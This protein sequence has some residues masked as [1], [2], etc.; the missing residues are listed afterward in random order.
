MASWDW[1]LDQAMTWEKSV[2]FLKAKT[3]L[4]VWK[5]VYSLWS[6][7]SVEQS[8][9]L[10]FPLMSSADLSYFLCS[11]IRRN[12]GPILVTFTRFVCIYYAIINTQI[13]L[14]FLLPRFHWLQSLPAELW[15][16]LLNE[17]YEYLALF[18]LLVMIC[19]LQQCIGKLCVSFNSWRGL[20][21]F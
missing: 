2:P 20:N 15:D 11:I 5:V 18:K 21:Q 16:Y 3:L 14:L 10:K 17:L 4:A 8:K 1:I 12:C 7:P 6:T 13:T 19:L 9:R